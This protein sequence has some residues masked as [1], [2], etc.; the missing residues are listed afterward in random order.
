MLLAL[1]SLDRAIVSAYG[2]C[3]LYV[4]SQIRSILTSREWAAAPEGVSPSDEQAVYDSISGQMV[5][6]CSA[7]NDCLFYSAHVSEVLA[8]EAV[9]LERERRRSGRMNYKVRSEAIDSISSIIT[10]TSKAFESN[11]KV[12]V[13]YLSSIIFTSVS[14]ILVDQLNEEWRK[15]C[16]LNSDQEASDPDFND[17]SR[18][19]NVVLTSLATDFESYK[20]FLNPEAYVELVR[21]VSDKFVLRYYALLKTLELRKASFLERQLSRFSYEISRIIKCLRKA[22][23][24]SPD[25]EMLTNEIIQK[26][27]RLTDA[28]DIIFHESDS[29]DFMEAVQKIKT[30]AMESPLSAHALAGF[31]KTCVTLRQD[32]PRLLQMEQ[33]VIPLLCRQIQSYAVQ[34][35]PVVTVG[36]Y[37][38][39]A[40]LKQDFETIARL[41]FD[42][43]KN[44]PLRPSPLHVVFQNESLWNMQGSVATAATNMLKSALNVHKSDVVINE[45]LLNSRI[46]AL[47]NQTRPFYAKIPRDKLPAGANDHFAAISSI[48]ETTAARRSSLNAA[49]AASSIAAVKNV[50]SSSSS[51]SGGGD[52]LGNYLTKFKGFFSTEDGKHPPS[53]GAN[54]GS[55]SGG[56]P[57]ESLATVS[58]SRLMSM[59]KQGI[60]AAPTMPLASL[61]DSSSMADSSNSYIEIREITVANLFTIDTFMSSKANV[62]VKIQLSAQ[63]VLTSVIANTL[64]P[65]WKDQHLK[66]FIPEGLVI[67][68]SI[69]CTVYYKKRIGSDDMIGTVSIPMAKLS[70]SGSIDETFDL[71]L[72]NSSDHVISCSVKASAEGFAAPTLTFSAVVNK[73]TL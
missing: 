35:P 69:V 13:D 54:Q 10:E 56:H 31:L 12:C 20:E 17:K 60:G 45:S 65:E 19:I 16:Q 8:A 40:E 15:E 42:E 2:T 33:S 72:S 1:D 26:F 38:K 4:A 50:A 11:V 68:E 3:F 47:L 23:I 67:H 41:A 71:N 29:D 49:A 5:W 48:V 51:S 18:A 39:E 30:I 28:N 66:L 53:P 43:A 34:P 58:A 14:S 9:E 25:E 64:R 70:A 21:I 32:G 57:E 36:Q 46:T 44:H 63:T 7:A 55:S 62:Y 6:V 24:G 61:L 52:S 37:S 73:S 59:V 27:A 22:I